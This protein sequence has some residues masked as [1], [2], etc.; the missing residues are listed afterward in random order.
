MKIVTENSGREEGGGGVFRLAMI[1]HDVPC[2]VSFRF[3]IFGVVLPSDSP[4]NLTP[5]STKWKKKKA[6]IVNHRL[7][8]PSP[9]W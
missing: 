3:F 6:S 2:R 5:G 9:P 4:R 7:H 8:H 1:F